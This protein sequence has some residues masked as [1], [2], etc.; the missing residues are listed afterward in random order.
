MAGMP[1]NDEKECLNVLARILL[2]IH[3]DNLTKKTQVFVPVDISKKAF[4]IQQRNNWEN[5]CKNEFNFG[6]K[7]YYSANWQN[8]PIFWIKNTSEVVVV[9]LKN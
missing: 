8:T 6:I 5:F 2:T 7:L 4:E 3:H 1:L 9:L